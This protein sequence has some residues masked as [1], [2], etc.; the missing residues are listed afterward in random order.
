[1]LLRSTRNHENSSKGCIMEDLVEGNWPSFLLVLKARRTVW[2]GR[3]SEPRTVA[4][5]PCDEHA[6]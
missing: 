5:G 1:M 6:K 3:L 2:P 4:V